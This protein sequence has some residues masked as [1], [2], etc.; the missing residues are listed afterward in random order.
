MGCELSRKSSERGLGVHWSTRQMSFNHGL[1]G[2]RQ[3]DVSMIPWNSTWFIKGKTVKY[4]GRSGVDSRQISF[5]RVQD[6]T[7]CY[8]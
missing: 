4:Q 1:L 8:L 5:G 2:Q 3:N 7:T 6:G